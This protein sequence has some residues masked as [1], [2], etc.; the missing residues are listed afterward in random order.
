MTPEELRRMA[1]EEDRLGSGAG[2]RLRMAADTIKR[3]TA[4][5]ERY[6]H[7]RPC[8]YAVMDPDI[9]SWKLQLDDGAVI[10]GYAGSAEQVDAAVDAAR[11]R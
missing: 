11:S 6:Q 9:P 5:A 8:L 2:D 7:L 3:M 4:D 10:A 1:D